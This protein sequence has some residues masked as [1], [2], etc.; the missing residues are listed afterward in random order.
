MS[1]DFSDDPDTVQSHTRRRRLA[2]PKAS[3]SD[4]V[5]LHVSART[6]EDAEVVLYINDQPGLQRIYRQNCIESA[7][8]SSA[9]AS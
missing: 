5:I 9:R 1:P 4:V 6:Q 8:P 7:H 3:A 2:V